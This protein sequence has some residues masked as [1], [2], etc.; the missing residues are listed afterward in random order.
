[1]AIISR[2]I[3]TIILLIKGDESENITR[4][5]TL[6][7][8]IKLTIRKYFKNTLSLNRKERE[9]LINI[10]AIR[11]VNPKPISLLPNPFKA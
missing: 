6:E 8:S 10:L 4:I 7:C 2:I 9:K 11:S 5:S 3:N 1:M